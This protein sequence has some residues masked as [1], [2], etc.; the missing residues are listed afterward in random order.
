MR[1]ILIVEGTS[2][3]HHLESFLMCEIVT[4][5]GSDIPRGTIEYLIELSLN[6]NNR[7]IVFT[8]PDGPGERIRKIINEKIPNVLNAFIDKRH[9]IK[10]KK[11]GI[12]ETDKSYLLEALSTL[13]PNFNSKISG[14]IT[15]NVLFTLGLLGSANSKV[16][17]N[18]LTQRLK[19]GIVNGKTLCN[20]LNS[21][22]ISIVTLKATIL[23]IKNEL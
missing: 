20:R 14:E 17:R 22:G 15:T 8:D 21:L 12:A 10:G 6:S 18:E 13:S 2:D 4:T 1:D 19:L 3:K 16:L 9:A 11:I 23:E 7:L 5:N